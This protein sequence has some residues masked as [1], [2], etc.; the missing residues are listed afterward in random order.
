MSKQKFEGTVP[1]LAGGLRKATT[2]LSVRITENW[3]NI[4][5]EWAVNT[6]LERCGY[7][8]SPSEVIHVCCVNTELQKNNDL[9]E[10]H[11]EKHGW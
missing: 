2:K 4:W 10:T 11:S 1:T 9:Y 6:G 5:K 8:R 3:P 7:I